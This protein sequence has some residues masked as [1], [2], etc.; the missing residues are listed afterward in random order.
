MRAMTVIP[1]DPGSARI[2]ERPEPPSEDGAVLVAGRLLGLCGTDREIAVDGYGEAPSG[3]ERLVIGHESLGDVLEAPP[4]SGFAPGDVVAGI[5]RRPDPVPCP[6]CAVGEWDMCR[7]G[8]VTERGIVRH[9]GYGAERW[10]LE[11]EFAVR[12]PPR[13]GDLGVLIEPASVLAKAWEQIDLISRRAFFVRERALVI[14]AGPIG[15]L[16]TLFGAQHGYQ[17]HVVDRSEHRRK[18]DLVEALGATFHSG[19]AE[20]IDVEADVLVECTGVGAAARAGI[21]KLASGGIGCLT[22]VAHG[23]PRFDADSTATNRRLVLRNQLL[24]GTVNAARRHWEQAAASLA[25]TDPQWLSGLITR[26]VPL[27][28]WTDGLEKEPDDIKVV[29]ELASR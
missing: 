14:G 11:P 13:L 12:V 16:A 6:A 26:H 9:H 18:R 27:D 8:L 17:V 24:F 2:D 22:G 15:L 21:R 28:R 23:E 1:G 10:R 20:D 3:E 4:G 19:D 29:V 25:A 5:V 7:N